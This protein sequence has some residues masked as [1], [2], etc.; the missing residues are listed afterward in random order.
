MLEI[1][2]IVHCSSIN[3]YYQCEITPVSVVGKFNVN[4]YSIALIIRRLYGLNEISV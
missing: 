4:H 3:L 1:Q 2:V